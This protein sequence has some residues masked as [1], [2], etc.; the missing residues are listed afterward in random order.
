M[1]RHRET[2]REDRCSDLVGSSTEPGIIHRATMPQESLH[3][4]PI[5]GWV[6]SRIFHSFQ[7]LVVVVL[8]LHFTISSQMG[9]FHC[10]RISSSSSAARGDSSQLHLLYSASYNH[11][12]LPLLFYNST[13]LTT[14][15]GCWPQCQFVVR[16]VQT[17]LDGTPL[18]NVRD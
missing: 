8:F 11:F 13:A 3:E 15:N 1:D 10:S 4:V 2:Q 5:H 16:G 14:P 18:G 9:V 7:L 17:R 6:M 12:R